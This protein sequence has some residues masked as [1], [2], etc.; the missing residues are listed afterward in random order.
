MIRDDRNP[1]KLVEHVIQEGD[2]FKLGRVQMRVKEIYVNPDN[3]GWKTDAEVEGILD[4]VPPSRKQIISFAS[5]HEENADIIDLKECY[6]QHTDNNSEIRCRIC[7]IETWTAADPLI[8]GWKC[9]GDLNLIHFNWLRN[10]LTTKLTKKEVD[11]WSSFNWKTFQ[12]EVW[13]HPY[14]YI[15]KHEFY[16]DLVEIKQPECPYL[17][18]ESMPN[19]RNSSRFVFMIKIPDYQT[20]NRENPA[21][22]RRF[23]IGRGHESDLRISDISVS[24]A[25]TDIEYSNGVFKIQ[26]KWSKFGTLVKVRSKY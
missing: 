9:Q 19:E 11:Y 10:W 4:F 15:F 23:S 24:R 20:S 22:K 21:I 18:L 2:I 5:E 6:T 25:H 26:D 13:N 1:N 8:R 14:P 17:I 12:W 3:E 16:Y 7:W